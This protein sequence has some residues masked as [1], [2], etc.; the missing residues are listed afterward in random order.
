LPLLLA[1]AAALTVGA[2]QAADA[3]P[4]APF[5]LWVTE[6]PAGGTPQ[7]N[8][9][10]L[11]G[12]RSYVFDGLG[13]APG[14]V[15]TGATI[16]AASLHDPSSVLVTPTG[17]LLIADRGFNVGS[18]AVSQVTFTGNVP[19]AATALL[20]SVD[21]GPHQIA[22]TGSGD[23]VVS[24]LVSGARLYPAAS[25]PPTV[26]YASGTERGAIV[27][28]SLLYSTAGSGNLQSFDIASGALLG[29]FGVSGATLLHYGTMFGGSLWLA[30]VGSNVSGAGGGIYRVTL[31]VNGNPVS[32][33]KVA[34]VNGAISVAF[35]PFGDEMLV[36]SHFDGTLTGYALSGTTVAA[37]SNLFI[38]GGTLAGWGGA[39]VQYGGLAVTAAVPEPAAWAS[40][41][42]GLLV[43]AAAGLRHRRP[44]L[45]SIAAA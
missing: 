7:F 17:S 30:D 40:M 15:S 3:A 5:T 14:N 1:L 21:T 33:A 22:L 36:A 35:S 31:D 20:S 26:S 9:Q 42:G 16:P 12:V 45:R 11:G 38:D 13:Y 37:S 39:H 34:N 43:M 6:T 28:G 8:T 24:S 18:G 10:Q 19:N 32:S 2:A 23:L 41:L 29:N 25:A 44:A 27:N 4:S